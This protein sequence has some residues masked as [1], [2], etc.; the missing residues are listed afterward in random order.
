M[1]GFA[2]VDGLDA[3]VHM[4][5]VEQQESHIPHRDGHFQVR[6]VPVQFCCTIYFIIF[7]HSQFESKV[8]WLLERT[9]LVAPKY[10]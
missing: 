7:S 8:A 9:P 4:V 6:S 2:D 10:L 3:I 5:K 1:S